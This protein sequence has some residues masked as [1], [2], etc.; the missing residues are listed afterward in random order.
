MGEVL[1]SLLEGIGAQLAH[2]HGGISALSSLAQPPWWANALG[3]LGLW[4][5]FAGALAYLVRRQVLSFPSSLWRVQ[6]SDVLFIVVGSAAQLLIDLAYRPFHLHTLNS[7]VKHLFGASHGA[8]FVL[9]GIMTT[10]LAPIME[11]LLFRGAV[12]RGLQHYLPGSASV[13]AWTSTVASAALFALAH[14]E[15]LQFGGLFALGLLLAWLV[16]KTGRLTPSIITHVSFNGVALI[17][18]S[19]Q[20]AGH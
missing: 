11:E 19:L 12:Y 9:I 6:L 16:K 7:P 4:T 17:A 1:A 15:P 18:L 2:F 8:S 10:L 13:V 14:G 20:R 3:L 5:G